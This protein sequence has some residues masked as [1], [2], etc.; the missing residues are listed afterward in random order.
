MIFKYQSKAKATCR[1]NAKTMTCSIVFLLYWLHVS[2]DCG[3]QMTFDTCIHCFGCVWRSTLSWERAA[4]TRWVCVRPPFPQW[5]WSKQR[6]RLCL[7]KSLITA[8]ASL[9]S[10]HKSSVQH[11]IKC[12]LP[13]DAVQCNYNAVAVSLRDDQKLVCYEWKCSFHMSV[14]A[15]FWWIRHWAVLY[16]FI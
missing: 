2:S 13:K 11:W 9:P 5:L 8:A 10:N 14:G 3:L 12:S 1:C 7:A 16:L 15:D 4:I 6:N